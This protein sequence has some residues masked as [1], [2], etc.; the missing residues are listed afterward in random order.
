VTLPFE[1]AGQCLPSLLTREGNW[2]FYA[3]ECLK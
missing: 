3:K 2:I 1:H